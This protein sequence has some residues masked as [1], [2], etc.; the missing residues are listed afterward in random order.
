MAETDSSATKVG[1]SGAD[2]FEDVVVH[3]AGYIVQQLVREVLE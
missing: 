2:A 3:Q 1:H